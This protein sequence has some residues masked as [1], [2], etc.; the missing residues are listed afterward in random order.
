M[1]ANSG[2]RRT[3]TAL[4]VW[5]AT[6]ILTGTA[7]GQTAERYVTLDFNRATAHVFD[8]AT[9]TE[10]AAIKV[11]NGPHSIVIS[12]NGRLAFV[13]HFNSNYVSVIDLTIA[14]EI[15]RIPALVFQLGISADGATV[16]GTDQND[17]GITVIDAST[18]S[19]IR[20]ISFNGR[21]GDDPTVDGD[22]FA[23]NPV[24]VG[25]KVYL[26]TEFDFGVIDLGTGIVTDLGSTPASN[27][28]DPIADVSVATA[29]GRFVMINRDGALV[30]INT[31]TN[32]VR[33]ASLDF[34]FAF[35]VSASRTVSANGVNYAYI[36]RIVGASVHLS[37]V[38]VPFGIIGDLALPQSFPIDL[39]AH[40]VP[41]SDGTRVL[42]TTHAVKN[43][44]IVDTSDPFAPALVGSPISLDTNIRGVDERITLNQPPATAPVVATVSA[45]L[46]VNSAATAL[47]VSG[48]GFAPD[49]QVRIGHLDPQAAQFISSSL[50]QVS[51]P[52]DAPAQDASIIVTNPNLSQGAA[53]ADQSGI[54]RNALVIASGPAFQ[55]S[56]EVAIVNAGDAT[57]SVLNASTTATPNPVFPAPDRI[58]GLA[59][60][61]DGKRGYVERTFA[62][63]TID[64]FN[65]LTNSFEAS[66]PLNASPAG[67]PGQTRGIVIAPRFSTGKPAAYVASSVRTGPGRFSLNLYVIDADPASAT[68][69]TVVAILPTGEPQASSTSGAIAVT[70]NGHFA[71][72]NGFELNGTGDLIIL[73]LTSGVS[74]VI[75]MGTLGVSA[76]QPMLELSPDARFLVLVA[77]DGSAHVFDVSN[78]PAPIL[79]ATIQSTPPAGFRPLRLLPRIIGNTMYTFDHVQNV[80]AIFNF[81]PAANNF[82]Q[83]ATFAFPAA[84]TNFAVVHDVTPD[85]KLMYLPLR[86]QDSVAVIDTAKVLAGDP[87]ALLTEIG[88]GISPHLAA[89]RPPTPATPVA[90]TTVTRYTGATSQN[91]HD[92]TNLSATLV[93][94]GTSAPIPGQTITF[95][96][97]TQ[98][99]TGTTGGSGV[100]ACSITLNQVAGSYTVNASF[101]GS[102]N[103]QASS[104]SAAFTITK[105]ETATSYTGPTVITNGANTTFSAV[106]KEDGAVAIA[107]RT[108]T[109]TLGSGSTAQTCSGT[110]DA[111]GTASCSILVNQ[112]LSAGTVAASFAGDAFYLPSSSGAATILFAT[113]TRY[114][115]ETTQNYHDITNLSATLVEQG[116]S[117]PIP[118]QTIAFTLGT[119]S[120]AGTTGSGGVAA[121][122]I[123]LN[124]VPGSYTVNASFAGSANQQASSASAGFTITREETATAYTGPTVIANGAN[125]TYSA[126]LKEDGAVAIAGR[127]ITI[128]LGSGNTAQTCT[129]T[130]DATGTASCSILVN[131]PLGPGTVA[132]SFAGDALYLLSSNGAA[133]IL[134]A[135]P[136]QGAFVLGNQTASGAVEFWGDNWATVNMLSGGPA[137]DAFKG[138]AA[139]T[140]EPPACGSAW[141]TDPGNSSQPPAGTLPSYMGVVVSTR[142]GQSGSTIS[143][144]VSRIIVV[145]PNAG[146]G[147]NPGQHGTGT[148]VATF[149]TTGGPT[150]AS[151]AGPG[152]SPPSPAA[153]LTQWRSRL[154]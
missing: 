134:F 78:P 129:G 54:L 146:Y 117:V 99:C 131:Q 28:L 56:N 77:N 2:N 130:T 27:F 147:P 59:I 110:S 26:E 135:F 93:V 32:L 30:F 70:P 53:G 58:V 66:V 122:S 153:L 132:A 14:A 64:V 36:L 41:N 137:P 19:V 45:P 150:S 128:M 123:V 71:F 61:P 121:C 102:G 84:P 47:Q 142:I 148:V 90:A 83:L 126:V 44:Y 17:D 65:F 111:T 81:N 1:K 15:K 16:V 140:S 138:F 67:Q 118:G 76:F 95:T 144:D 51:V 38:D 97:G 24:V 116:T 119:Q 151:M 145:T 57:L 12:P 10:V 154:F 48:S 107:G 133:T 39:L 62:P 86:E 98:S 50:L 109:I 82:S 52:A 127:T 31:S 103:D 22:A 92:I 35:A 104:D 23:S 75:P 63:A 89:V 69:N 8:A 46:V 20:T 101:A 143:G 105:K 100:A 40:I 91:F 96:L 124:Q 94:Q 85:G 21:L 42:L 79:F 18:L 106:L 80:V 72:V 34:T 11:G 33:S 5:V 13:S 3:A 7:F 114:T 152:S 139:N 108:I 73:D 55:P 115:G 4:I 88:A 125:T 37:I 112:P 136:A 74:T 87:S 25:N 29:D 49:A 6:L 9:N 120:C 68:F 149:C 43:V 141:T 60:T 113:V